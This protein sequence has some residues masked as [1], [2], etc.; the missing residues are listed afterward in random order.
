MAGIS[1]PQTAWQRLWMVPMP[2]IQKGP[3]ARVNMVPAQASINTAKIRW[4]GRR[5]T[6]VTFTRKNGRTSFTKST[7]RSSK[8]GPIFGPSSFGTCLISLLTHALKALP[9]DVM[10]KA[11]SHTTARR[12][13]TLFIITRPIGRPTQWSI[14]PATRSPIV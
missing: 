10:T 11:W 6:T 7:G 5:P 8:P 14:L 12:A 3:P 13:R 1:L 9:T 4:P 2:V